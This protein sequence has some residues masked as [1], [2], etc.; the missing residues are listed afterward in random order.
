MQYSGLDLNES[1]APNP[2]I[3]SGSELHRVFIEKAEMNILVHSD[4]SICFVRPVVATSCWWF[5]TSSTQFGKAEQAV[6]LPDQGDVS[7]IREVV[8]ARHRKAAKEVGGCHDA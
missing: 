5:D 4:A 6:V 7:F 2:T 1:S 3:L 8:D